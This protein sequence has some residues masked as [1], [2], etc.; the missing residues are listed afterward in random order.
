MKA[1]RFCQRGSQ[2]KKKATFFENNH[3]KC[4]CA[5]RRPSSRVKGW[6]TLKE[7]AGK[8]E[9]RGGGETQRVADPPKKNRP[10]WRQFRFWG[11]GRTSSKEEGKKRIDQVVPIRGN[12]MHKIKRCLSAEITKGAGWPDLFSWENRQMAKNLQKRRILSL[13]IHTHMRLF[14][15]KKA[16][17]K[18]SGYSKKQETIVQ[19]W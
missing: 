4:A 12:K 16:T 6:W 11:R 1:L 7:E 14:C 17:L 15:Q 9:G 5:R 13:S 19:S 2:K 18:Y 8:M 10:L 3:P